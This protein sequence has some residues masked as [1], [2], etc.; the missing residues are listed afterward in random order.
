MLGAGFEP[1]KL[2]SHG[3]PALQQLGREIDFAPCDFVVVASQ[4]EPGSFVVPQAFALKGQTCDFCQMVGPGRLEPLS[5][6]AK[7][8]FYCFGCW[9][10]WEDEARL[11]QSVAVQL[12]MWEDG[13][14]S[15]DS[16]DTEGMELPRVEDGMVWKTRGGAQ[17]R[18]MSTETFNQQQ[19]CTSL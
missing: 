10:Q 9:A 1:R 11:P 17:G 2:Y 5:N 13:R 6:V 12:A 15:R 18:A 16:I 14:D 3:S 19:E 8:P 7:P 4:L